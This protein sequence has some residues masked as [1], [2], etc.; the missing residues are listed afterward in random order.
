MAD[1][2]GAVGDRGSTG[3]DGVDVGRVHCG[4][5]PAGLGSGGGGKAERD[6]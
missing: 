5:G 2:G 3:G 4:V 1:S 6:D